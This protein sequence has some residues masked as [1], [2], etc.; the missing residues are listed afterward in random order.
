SE[1]IQNDLKKFSDKYNLKGIGIAAPSVNHLTGVIEKAVNLHWGEVD[2]INKMKKYFDTHIVI[3]NDANAAALGEGSFGA[4]KGM[5]NFISITLGTGLGSGI[6][7][8]G[9]LLYGENGLAGEIGHSIIE[10]NGRKC[11][12]GKFGCLETYISAT[13]L[14]RTVFNFLSYYD[15]ASELRDI[16]YNSM[17]S[18]RISELAQKNDAI[19]VKAYEY[20][21]DVLARSLSNLVSLFNPEAIILFGGL[22]DSGDLLLKPLE[23]YMDKYL[24][25]LYKGKIKILKSELQ[26]G[27]AAILGVCSFVKETI[28]KNKTQ[29]SMSEL[30]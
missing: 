23:H 3:M 6:V 15:D 27:K 21:G 2:F 9:Q 28:G 4:A 14:K 18:K 20:T 22:A 13:G 16:S 30:K 7:V 12:C 26:N 8:N 11:G 1:K 10:P 19:A 29:L 25:D 17:T 5:N 24:L